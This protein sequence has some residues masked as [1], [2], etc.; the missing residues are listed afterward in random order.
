MARRTMAMEQV[1]PT[2]FTPSIEE[3]RLE[4]NHCPRRTGSG[5]TCVVIHHTAGGTL[6]S[7]WDWFNDPASQC[8]AH[9]LIGE[10]GT[11]I[12]LVE[13]GEKS[14]HAGKSSFGGQVNVNEISIGIELV[15]NG[16][17]HPYAQR[18]LQA[19][20][21]L[22]KRLAKLYEIPTSNFVGHSD[23]SPGRKVDPGYF[24]N[25]PWFRNMIEEKS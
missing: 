1:L 16:N 8:S 10:D 14:W 20:V 25:W 18:Q 7:N 15:G 21:W 19:L 4:N 6:D 11:I 22:C 24:F 2:V 12:H 9:Y 5:L 17:D 13:D 3:R 23:I